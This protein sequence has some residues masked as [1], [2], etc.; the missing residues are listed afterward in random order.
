LII[1][2]SINHEKRKACP[3]QAEA[4]KE[5]N[6]M[7]NK[8]KDMKTLIK[9]RVIEGINLWLKNRRRI[10]FKLVGSAMVIVYLIFVN[11][12]DPILKLN[13]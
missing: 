6:T 13:S 8:K 9:T 10:N 3:L 11:G 5:E 12:S 1:W 4:K 2:R 7:T